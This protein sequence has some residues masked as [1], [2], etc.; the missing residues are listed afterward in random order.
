M[1]LQETPAGE[2][3]WTKGWSHLKYMEENRT[4][5]ASHPTNYYLEKEKQWY[6]QEGKNYA[7]Q[8]SSKRLTRPN[9]Q[10]DLFRGEKACSSS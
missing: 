3:V 1:V 4:Q 5:V 10:I 8:K 7:P 6:T 9:A 2:W